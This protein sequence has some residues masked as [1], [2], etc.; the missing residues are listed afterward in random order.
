ML[1][2]PLAFL[3]GLMN[4]SLAEKAMLLLIA[5]ASEAMLFLHIRLSGMQ[6]VSE[7]IERLKK[8]NTELY[9]EIQRKDR[10]IEQLKR[11]LAELRERLVMM[12]E[13]KDEELALSLIK[14]FQSN[15]DA[16]SSL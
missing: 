10:E 6:K 13:K 9:I 8:E 5:G 12:G 11:E 4:F 7:R 15:S 16:S 1:G 3:A 2:L 14:S